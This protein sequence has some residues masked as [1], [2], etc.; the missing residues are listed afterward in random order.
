M[1]SPSIIPAAP[2]SGTLYGIGLG[3]GAPELLTIRGLQLLQQVSV[4]FTPGGSTDKPSYAEQIAGHF[5]DPAKQQI[6]PLP[7]TFSRVREG[8]DRAWRAAADVV[9]RWIGA[10]HS[11]AFVT[12][13]DPLTYST[14]IHL[15]LALRECHPGIPVEIVPGISSI[16]AASAAACYPLVDQD[17]RLA[18]L[19]APYAIDSLPQ[20]LQIFDTVVLL[21]VNSVFD[22]L[23]DLLA[24]HSLLNRS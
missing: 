8:R 13:G 3:P 14:F 19:P 22:R 1:D 12:E 21:K 18:V 23:V 7:V 10:G 6:I 15:F 20:I 11:A 16:Q 17:E 9:A 24:E 4:I 5:L 2:A